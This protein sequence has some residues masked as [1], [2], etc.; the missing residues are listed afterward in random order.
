MSGT[1]LAYACW[2]CAMSG[3]ERAYG[4]ICRGACYA[5]CGTDLAYAATRMRVDSILRYPFVLRAC[6]A[7]SGID[8]GYAAT[9]GYVMYGTDIGYAATRPEQSYTSSTC[10]YHTIPYSST[11]HRVGSA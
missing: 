8:V 7:M 9:H 1:D 3:T 6:Y 10:R 11:G 2:C 4:A 5:V